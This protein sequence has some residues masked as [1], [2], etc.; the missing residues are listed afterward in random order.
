MVDRMVYASAF[1]QIA[2]LESAHLEAHD[3]VAGFCAAHLKLEAAAT[4][5]TLSKD[6]TYADVVEA[7]KSVHR[8]QPQVGMSGKA[9]PA[10]AKK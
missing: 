7:V 8:A 10:P 2:T 3:A 5:G 9:E 6:Q 4:A 1:G